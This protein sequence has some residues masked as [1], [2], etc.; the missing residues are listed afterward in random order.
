[1]TGG[2][3]VDKLLELNS[4]ASRVMHSPQA[5][6]FVTLVHFGL[7]R[8]LLKLQIAFFSAILMDWIYITQL[9]A[10]MEQLSSDFRNSRER[11]P[12]LH[13]G[14]CYGPTF[15]YLV[16]ESSWF[17]F[18]SESLSVSI[19]KKISQV[20][21]FIP[22]S[23]NMFNFCIEWLTK[24][25]KRMADGLMAVNFAKRAR[26]MRE[27]PPTHSYRFVR[28]SFRVNEN[29][30]LI[31]FLKPFY[32]FECNSSELMKLARRHAEF[33]LLFRPR[34]AYLI[35]AHCSDWLKE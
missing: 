16:K 11:F 26:L 27:W 33:K 9:A 30:L 15:I 3:E 32:L 13:G 14:L 2:E 18:A 35:I 5:S 6:I 21:S 23:V 34:D 24:Y 8:K 31:L 12:L 1:M 4:N 7:Q 17:I 29:S 25:V 20:D 22:F 19:S 28:W 10:L